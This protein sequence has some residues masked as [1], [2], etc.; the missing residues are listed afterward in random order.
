MDFQLKAQIFAAIREFFTQKGFSEADTPLLVKHPDPSLYHEVFEVKS[1]QETYYLSPSPE[2]YLKKLISEGARNIYQI[3]KSFRENEE[4][5]CL[6]LRE[7]TILEWYRDGANYSDL[8]ADCQNLVALIS[9]KTA[10][11]S[12]SPPYPQ[13]TCQEVFQRYAGVNLIE[14]LDINKARQIAQKKGY[15]VE[16]VTTWEQLYHQ[17][18]LN[19][20]E[21]KLC[22]LPAFF[23]LDYPPL[24]AELAQTKKEPPHWAERVE[25]HLKGLEIANGYTELTDAQ[26]Q[27]K[28]FQIDIQE[29]KKRGMK[30]FDYDRK[31]IA[32]LKR[33]LP[34]TAGMALGV[35]RLVMALTGTKDIHQITLSSL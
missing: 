33:G 9:Q 25:F 11:K 19:E 22:T 24:L 31:F 23:L 5:D 12:P 18:F 35:D 29:R 2:I 8:I 10:L 17:I 30:V 27:K 7:F 6:H 16:K 21:P 15:R 1:G 26:E 34:P 3:T 4:N 13:L 28:R 20:V 14:F 32:A